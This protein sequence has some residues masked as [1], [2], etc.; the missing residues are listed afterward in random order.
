MN[1][2]PVTSLEGPELE[3][4]RTLRETTRH[5]R[6]GYAVVE[7]GKVVLRLLQ[8]E[9][10]VVSFLMTSEWFEKL[11]AMLSRPRYA[12]TPVFIA[13]QEALRRIVGFP[14]HNNVMALIRIP[15][16]PD[17]DEFATSGRVYV[18]VEGIA[19]A[20]N[21]GMIVRN[22][23]AFGVSGLI[24]G[25]DSCS[26][27]L[28]RAVRVSVG[29]VF[30]LP[31]FHSADILQSLRGAKAR[32]SW[33]IVATV[34]RGGENTLPGDDPICLFF[35]SEGNG[36]TDDALGICD[37]LFTIPIRDDIDSLNVANATAIALY[38]AMVV[39]RSV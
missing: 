34:P 2:I 31:V 7:S 35:G 33:R 11:H 9:A 16:N 38:H 8:S 15:E 37:A 20:E 23:A 18:A 25:S 27:Y 6:E 17:W 29:A 39:R 21:I 30:S 4:Y 32:H 5:W 14:L 26:P 36:L 22:C 19:D 13:E 12:R 28:R 10:D 24:V 1:V 3:P